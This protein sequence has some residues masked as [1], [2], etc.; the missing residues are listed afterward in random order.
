M[1][2]LLQSIPAKARAVI[3]GTYTVAVFVVGA[4]QVGYA[5]SDSGTPDW[6]GTA[7][8]VAAYVGVA[9]GVTAAANTGKSAETTPPV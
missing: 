4:I 6:V 1:I 7:L 2:N 9:I 8:A 3:Y 5:Q